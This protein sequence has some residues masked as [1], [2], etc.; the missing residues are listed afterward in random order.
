MWH[1]VLSTA[2]GSRLKAAVYSL[3]SRA[4]D[5]LMRGASSAASRLNFSSFIINITAKRPVNAQ[6]KPKDLTDYLH[7][8]HQIKQS[9]HCMYPIGYSPSF[10]RI[11]SADHV[12][13]EHQ[14]N[15][16]ASTMPNNNVRPIPLRPFALK[17]LD[18]RLTVIQTE[19]T[20]NSQ[21]KEFVPKAP[22]RYIQC[23]YSWL[24]TNA[25]DTSLGLQS[26]FLSWFAREMADHYK[27][28]A[29]VHKAAADRHRQLRDHHFAVA[30]VRIWSSWCYR[31][32]VFGA[33]GDSHFYSLP[34][35]TRGLTVNV[36]EK[37]EKDREPEPSNK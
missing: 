2:Q 25:Q 23:H 26:M 31:S 4:F 16:L 3:T 21:P 35:K 1:W 30:N 18:G 19:E 29:K 36:W 22:V 12:S 20:G 13:P 37:D 28:M 5:G 11:R 9:Q 17:A 15:Q 8:Y 14:P 24:R 10:G 34:P 33:Q 6:K 7:S 32:R 27:Q